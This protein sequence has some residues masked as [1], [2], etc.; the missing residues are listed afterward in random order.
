[1]LGCGS[2]GVLRSNLRPLELFRG[3]LPG[4]G[5]AFASR[6]RGC[7]SWGGGV[8]NFWALRRSRSLRRSP[9]LSLEWELLRRQGLASPGELCFDACTESQSMTVNTGNADVVCWLHCLAAFISFEVLYC[10][11]TQTILK[12]VSS[13]SSDLKW[14]VL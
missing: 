13:S 1:M 9:R 10:K 14:R 3:A 12:G 2:S 8:S 6:G 7:G 5:S 4:R 11:G